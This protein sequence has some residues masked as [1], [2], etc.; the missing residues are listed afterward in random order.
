MNTT[1]QITSQPRGRTT[2]LPNTTTPHNAR[3][4]LS[5]AALTLLHGVLRLAVA[6]MLVTTLRA[7]GPYRWAGGSGADWNVAANWLD[8]GSANVVPPANDHAIFPAGLTPA[9][10]PVLFS[11]AEAINEITFNMGSADFHVG[12]W[13]PSL[14]FTVSS[15][16]HHH[17]TFRGEIHPDLNTGPALLLD[18]SGSGTVALHGTFNTSPALT[19]NSTAAQP[20]IHP[21]FE[22][23]NR[24]YLTS[25]SFQSITVN[26][27]TLKI[28]VSNDV[29][30]AGPVVVNGG[31]LCVNKPSWTAANF[32]APSIT[33]NAGGTLKGN[34]NVV[35]TTTPFVTVGAGAI[36]APGCS[37]ETL[38]IAGGLTLGA[39]SVAEYELG[40]PGTIGGGVSDLTEVAGNLVLNG[41]L[42]VVALPGFG[43][44][45]YRLFNYTATLGGSGLALG[46]RP[47]GFNYVIDTATAGQVNL[48]VSALPP[49]LNCVADKTVECGTAWSFD[50]PSAIDPGTGNAVTPMIVST[51][52]L[53][54]PC[55][56]V[57]QRTWTVTYASGASETCSQTVTVQDTT[58][59]S[60]T[61][62]NPTPNL[63]PNPGFETLSAC[64]SAPNQLNLAPPWFRPSAGTPDLF[65]TCA[66]SPMVQVPVNHVGHQMPHSGN[67]YAGGTA[68]SVN[69]DMTSS[70]REYI[71]T[72]LSSALVAG[73]TY[74]VSFWVCSSEDFMYAID[75]LGAYLSVGPMTGGSGAFGVIPQVRNPA[76][77]FLTSTNTWTLI[78]GT[79]V[80]AGGENHLTLG[81]M[82]DDSTTAGVKIGGYY[83]YGIGAFYFYDDVTVRELCDGCP[84]DVTVECGSQWSFGT[85]AAW[86][87]CSATVSI[88]I[89]STVH[90]GLSHTRTWL[91]T[92]ACGNTATCS[93]TITEVN[94]VDLSLLSAQMDCQNNTV[95]LTFSKPLEPVSA[96]DPSSYMV[97]G[98]ASVP[99]S[100][101]FGANQNTVCLSLAPLANGTHTLDVLL[102][103]DNCGNALSTTINFDVLCST[104][105]CVEC[106]TNKTVECTNT[107]SFDSPTNTCTNVVVTE[108][109][110]V[111]E[112]TC[113]LKMTR[114]WSIVG[115]DGSNQCSQTVT[116]LETAS[117]SACGPLHIVLDGVV[118]PGNVIITWPGGCQLQASD[119]LE[120][121]VWANV[122][123]TSPL[124][125]NAPLVPPAS[126][127]DPSAG[128]RFFRTLSADGKC[129]PNI[130]GYVNLTL[131]AGFTLI[132]NP[133]NNT[134]NLLD[135][136]LPLDVTADGTTITR[137]NPATQNW[138]TPDTFYY[139]LGWMDQNIVSSS[140]PLAPGEGAFITVPQ[141]TVVT[142]VGEAPQGILVNPL[143]AGFSAQA[144]IAAVAGQ[145][146]AAPWLGVPA[147]HGD[148]I[149]IF[150]PAAQAY[151]SVYTY[152]TS[153]GWSSAN[154]DDPGPLGPFIP[155]GTG[156]FY[157]N[158][159][160]ARNWT[161]HFVLSDCQP[162]S[163]IT[164]PTNKEVE[165]GMAWT[166]DEPSGA[167][168]CCTNVTVTVLNTVTNSGC[169]T[170]ITRW[171]QVADCCT[172]T[173][174]CAQTVTVHDRTPPVFTGGTGFGPNLVPNPS[175]ETHSLCPDDWSQTVR[176][177][178]WFTPTMGTS[179]LFDGCASMANLAVP[180][181]FFG[182][183][184]AHSGNAYAGGYSY[185]AGVPG[186]RE[187]VEV[188]L[189]AP[190]LAGQT[191]E[192]SFYAALGSRS[193]EASDNIGAHLSAGPVT[194][195]SI[196]PLPVTPQVRNAAGSFIT[197]GLGWVLVQGNYTALGGEDHIT[198][199]NF[200]DDAST[201]R[202]PN[203]GSVQTYAYYHVDDVSVRL[204]G[205][206]CLPDK[207]VECGT[208]WSFDVPVVSDACCGNEITLSYVDTVVSSSACTQV[209]TRTWTAVDCCTNTATCSQTVTIIDTTAPKIICPKD[210][211]VNCDAVWSFN[212]PTV[213]DDCS[214]TNVVV[215]VL[216]TDVSTG[217]PTIITRIWQA[218]DACGNA[219][220]CTQ[221]VTVVDTTAPV[222][223]F[224]K[225]IKAVTC[226]TNIQLFYS[227]TA[228]DTCDPSVIPVCFPPSGSFFPVG[229]TMVNCTATDDCGNTVTCSFPVK[230]VNSATWQRF[231][232]GVNDC[233]AGTK[234]KASPRL[235]LKQNYPGAIWKKF[236]QGTVN[237]LFG[238]SWI[239]PLDTYTDG[240]L[241]TRMKDKQCAGNP[242]NDTLS[243][244]LLGCTTG[245]GWAWTR[246]L[247][248]FGTDPGLR[249]GPWCG[250]SGCDHT[251][252][253]PLKALPVASGSPV[254]VMPL[255]N[256]PAVISGSSASKRRFD[257]LVSNDTRVDYA[258]LYLRRCNNKHQVGGFDLSL[259][260]A[261]L[262]HGPA[263]WTLV[264][265]SNSNDVSSGTLELGE[266]SA[267]KLNFGGLRFI[268]VPNGAPF[269]ISA[270]GGTDSEVQEDRNIVSLV[271]NADDTVSVLLGTPL[272][273]A[274][275][276]LV[277]IL[278]NGVATSSQTLPAAAGAEMARFPASMPV[279]SVSLASSG[280]IS[281]GLGNSYSIQLKY[282]ND[283]V[284]V[285]P[286][287]A[288]SFVGYGFD[289]ITLG[290]PEVDIVEPMDGQHDDWFASASGET[291]ARVVN[292]QFVLSALDSA[293]P[294]PL[295]I[296]ARLASPTN[297]M[298]ATLDATFGQF[299]PMSSNAS[300]RFSPW[301]EPMDGQHDDVAG[302]R[303]INDGTNWRVLGSRSNAPLA[304]KRVEV[305]NNGALVAAVTNPASVTVS[306]LP[307]AY[308]PTVTWFVDAD[309][310]HRFPY[311]QAVTV[312]I[313][314]MAHAGNEVRI[315][316]AQ[317]DRHLPNISGIRVETEGVETL[318]LSSLEAGPAKYRLDPP[319]FESGRL[320]FGWS[321]LGAVVES[322]PTVRGPWNIELPVDGEISVP[323]TNGPMKFF[324]VR[325]Q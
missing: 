206:G 75:N 300:V 299:S 307:K 265:E 165:C 117:V 182:T 102:V 168:C 9:N 138:E 158:V 276:V 277:Q 204:Q 107:W 141:D 135:T 263:T 279:T 116:V 126:A 25:I 260:N 80:A 131:K 251:F 6:L 308:W 285:W 97:D 289:E 78:R 148:Q 236:D 258:D 152:S 231:P 177:T 72:P 29:N 31:T 44:G 306:E 312:Q 188:K 197:S 216:N 140:V 303:F 181:N 7:V 21:E 41:T 267:V 47:A 103:M 17:S 219:R 319:T 95:C 83:G 195:S 46:P 180:V 283:P 119:T 55:P 151:K 226:E 88:S 112:N 313:N 5:H 66:T 68:Y 215:T 58:P 264:K 32:T 210:K 213:T 222:I 16:I 310:C 127:S 275:N 130:V 271:K 178:P 255:I 318:A 241:I 1:K 315:L 302:V 87:A 51:T 105:P 153:G 170:V 57:I 30:V 24:G 269:T 311:S 183:L 93:Q 61:C 108:I 281:L 45:T 169:P 14:P 284:I 166:F 96:L 15:A 196:Y 11:A 244:G 90:S 60:F 91:A 250:I 194:G 92:D 62:P 161:Q 185:Y 209:V 257:M 164:C 71:E 218:V 156:F 262:V 201:P 238:H 155:V 176:A 147:G 221:R 120:N 190:L 69:G 111:T 225:K 34:A 128:K 150:D 193:G 74:E 322:A 224:P 54:G 123:G 214:G 99:L 28:A 179:D 35:V 37:P 145:V 12:P 325:G 192:V 211:T 146:G 85:P 240:F 234:E 207:T 125:I 293:N 261:H 189:A 23:N 53:S 48:V 157:R 76:G 253:L 122:A 314:G 291:V 82:Y 70:S 42:K 282:G 294:G 286:F 237:R 175:F 134:N 324:R 160:A 167:D 239:L 199:G 26:G 27:G 198:I 295:G 272:P 235:C 19:V 163:C 186:Y 270:Q 114:T 59:P 118:R 220:T 143:P 144:S 2:R 174:L 296:T 227:V 321:G 36:L 290:Q 73:K 232:G 191:Y 187:Y 3:P 106:P 63:V 248:T 142:L 81:N 100:A 20:A 49:G 229:T 65:H 84:P 298:R 115:P 18:G 52:T 104:N 297:E 40:T 288:V 304:L 13:F 132:A 305:W 202:I 94:G 243:L 223:S 162:P 154:S 121:P 8:A 278:S 149:F 136:I 230:V 137:F 287:T 242:M 233:Y 320:T 86:D 10:S 39:G 292:G 79:F 77:N 98:G 159:G 64:P 172:N 89:V 50:A 246:Q 254:N 139:G 268:E 205:T 256:S 171:W 252:M 280:A 203:P 212:T 184:A 4:R 22:I 247:G 316:V 101:A 273:G 228:A 259:A 113:P 217:C 317:D 33:V 133:L 173:V 301:V 245:S 56:Q 124:T 208:N 249:T 129:S 323:T 309:L 67:G 266:A 110:T 38:S 43:A 274:S 200:Y 109:S